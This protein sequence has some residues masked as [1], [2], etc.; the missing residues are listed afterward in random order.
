MFESNSAT[1]SLV[2]KEMA[3]IK[4]L[5]YNITSSIQDSVIDIIIKYFIPKPAKEIHAKLYK[6]Y[7]EFVA[8]LDTNITLQEA[9]K[10]LH[11]RN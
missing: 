1:L 5:E 4:N 9:A 8:F 6:E 11:S 7:E 3:N 10:D 2:Y